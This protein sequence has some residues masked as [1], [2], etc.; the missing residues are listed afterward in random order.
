MN[1]PASPPAAAKA[2]AVDKP[3]PVGNGAP[4]AKDKS[5]RV[6]YTVKLSSAENKQL[7]EL[8]DNCRLAGMRVSRAKL[9][10]AA[11]VLLNQHSSFKISEQL[12]DLAPLKQERKKKHK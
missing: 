6:E 7:I 10:R 9:L 5:K 4:G 8:R 11:V 2:A 12:H 3:A 1:K